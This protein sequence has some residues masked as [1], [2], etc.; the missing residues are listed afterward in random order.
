MKILQVITRR[1][2]R[3]AEVFATQLSEA[4]SARGCEVML[5]SLYGAGEPPL[6]SPEVPTVDLTEVPGSGLRPSC[7]LRLVSL[8]RQERPDIVQANGSDSL[9]YTVLARSLGSHRVPI[10]YRNI[11]L[12]S[13]WLRGPIH[14]SW[15]RWLVGRVD[16]VAAVSDTTR[17]D[18][19]RTYGINGSRLTTIPIGTH[20]VQE[21]DRGASRARLA[22]VVPVTPGDAVVAHV[23]SF[24]P[25]KNHRQIIEAF[26]AVVRDIPAAKLVLF[27][28]GELRPSMKE[29]VRE[30]DLEGTVFFAGARPDAPEL[31]AGA[32]LLVLFSSVEGIPGVVLEASAVAVPTVSSRVGGVEEAV[33]HGET[34]ILVP[35]DDTEAFVREVIGLLEDPTRRETMGRRARELVSARFGLD[36]VTE[37]FLQLY[38]RLID[39]NA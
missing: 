18:F 23:G 10:V 29:L 4:L 12:A 11:S 26:R 19:A 25:E 28:D 3:G 34:G 5:A 24:S 6:T 15:N 16:H 35:A 21:L 39:G 22:E 36:Q 13:R 30:A 27:G 2:L 7:L 20:P 1:Q 14:R 31:V 38:R 37:S 17:Q 33:V 8:L 32:D 9:K